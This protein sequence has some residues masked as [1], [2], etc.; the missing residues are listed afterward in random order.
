MKP[1]VLLILATSALIAFVIWLTSRPPAR[2]LESARTSPPATTAR[3]PAPPH[4]IKQSAS[5][6]EIRPEIPAAEP[7]V[8]QT[9]RSAES[10]ASSRRDL[11]NPLV[12]STIPAD[13]P[14][15]STNADPATAIDLDK[16]SLMFRDYRTITG[17][18][19]VGT[20]AEIMKSIMGGNPK[21]AMLG[22]PEG[23]TLNENGE[24]LDRW[25]TPYFFH[26]LTKDLMEIHSAG[27]DRKLGSD[28]D[29]VSK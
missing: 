22:P 16:I 5:P 24:L 27:P 1:R 18:N 8:A 2:P 12:P 17:E 3:V 6:G 11:E 13:L 23:Q 4:A 19:P 28:D 15:T 26:Q 9:P 7:P 21:G 20:N 10:R 25:G 14:A 29:V